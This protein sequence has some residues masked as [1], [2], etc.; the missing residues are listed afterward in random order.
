M[1]YNSSRSKLYGELGWGSLEIRRRNHRFTL[2]YK[3]VNGYTPDYL[4]EMLEACKSANHNYNLRATRTHTLPQIKAPSFMNSFAPATI[5]LW[6]N[7]PED[8][9]NSPSILS[10]KNKLKNP[11][12]HANIKLYDYGKRKTNLPT[13]Q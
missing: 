9:I 13:S 1:R 12:R 10:F 6:N 8:T 7:I 4:A 11:I 3:I 5:K 2:S